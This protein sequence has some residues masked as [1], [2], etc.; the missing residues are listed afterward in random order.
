MDILSPDLLW[1]EGRCY[2]LPSLDFEN[3][4]DKPDE[5]G[6]DI[7]L[8]NGKWQLHYVYL[9]LH[10]NKITCNHSQCELFC[11]AFLDNFLLQN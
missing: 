9:E 7:W 10:T 2:R 11:Q 8:E 6:N 1:I 4:R 5:M 3:N